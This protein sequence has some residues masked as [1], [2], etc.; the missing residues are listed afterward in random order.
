MKYSTA[1]RAWLLIRAKSLLK[2]AHFCTTLCIVI[3]LGAS[4]RSK[5][6]IIPSTNQV[7]A[8]SIP[9]TP[10]PAAAPAQLPGNGLAQHDFFYAGEQKNR[11]MYIVRNGK[12][13]WSYE[14]ST[15]KGEISDAVLLSNGNVVFAHQFGVTEITPDKKVIW[16]Y[17]APDKYEIHTAQPIGKNR[18]LFIDNGALPKLVL[19]NTTSGQTERQWPLTVKNPSKTHGQFRHARLTGAG[20]LLVAHMD[21]DKVSEYDVTGKE[22]WS[23]S[24]LSPWSASRL[25][26]GDT[27]VVSNQKFVREVNP[28]GETVW[29]FT[30]ADVPDY[31]VA[32]FQTASRLPNGNTLVNNWANPWRDS[33]NQTNAPVQAWEVTPDKKIVWALR[34]WAP[35][36]ALGAATNIQLLDQPVVPEGVHFG[37]IK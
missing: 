13:V 32:G 24:V 20:T 25:K 21:S 33:V 23:V 16:S 3:L 15:G 22:I 37:D 4:S 17:D 26:N 29:E 19:V 35:P 36:A 7:S 6:E 10:K 31:T 28:K 18:V 34:S 12:V 14:N 27:L 5:G 1:S 30:P 8:P 2:Q 9:V 11:N